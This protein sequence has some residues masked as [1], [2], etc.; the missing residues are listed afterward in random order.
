VVLV[1]Q[2]LQF[3]AAK[4]TQLGQE[5]QVACLS[6]P[7]RLLKFRMRIVLVKFMGRQFYIDEVASDAK[8]LKM[9][10][11]DIKA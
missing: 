9:T 2:L 7:V 4:F 5:Q 8:I 1:F 6:L 11:G 10:A 3:L